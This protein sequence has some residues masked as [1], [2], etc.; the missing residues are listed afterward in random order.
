MDVIT[1]AFEIAVAAAID[2]ETL[3]ASAEEM[4]EE[5]VS[6]I[7]T[8]GIRTQQPLHARNQIGPGGFDD[9]MEMVAPF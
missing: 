9:Q 8:R 6:A 3:V 7:E 5:L 1:N 4:P 2:E